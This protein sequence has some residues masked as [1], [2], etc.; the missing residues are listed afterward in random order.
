MRKKN[1]SQKEREEM[2]SDFGQMDIFS[3]LENGTDPDELVQKVDA[4]LEEKKASIVDLSKEPVGLKTDGT[5][6]EIEEEPELELSEFKNKLRVDMPDIDD[7]ISSVELDE[8]FAMSV[9]QE[10]SNPSIKELLNV[11]NE[12]ISSSELASM[13]NEDFNQEEK[14]EIVSEP[15]EATYYS[16]DEFAGSEPDFDDRLIAFDT[17]LPKD[18]PKFVIAVSR[19]E[20]ESIADF[21]ADFSGQGGLNE[22]T[23]I[24][25]P[26]KAESEPEKVVTMYERKIASANKI[27]KKTA[28]KEARKIA[29]LEASGETSE[30]M[31]EDLDNEPEAPKKRGR[32]PK[33]M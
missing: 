16:L 7:H 28:D 32:K 6:L 20:Y 3:M 33:N 17:S 5:N 19:D 1:Y 26:L 25:L 23:I 22:H 8:I 14:S 21:K 9:E 13:L 11:I 10:A 31:P 18:D 4:E 27:D 24:A 30:D 2:E 29:K 15:V 12:N